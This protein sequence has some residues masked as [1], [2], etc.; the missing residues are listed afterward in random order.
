MPAG[1]RATVVVDT[2]GADVFLT[3]KSLGWRGTIQ[4]VSRSGLLPLAHFKG[5]EYNEF[6]SANVAQSRLAELVESI[7]RHCAQL[8]ERGAN[9][10]IL[11]DKLRP[12]SQRIWQNFTLDEK[13]EFCRRYRSRWNTTR[14]RIA[15]QIHRQLREAIDEGTLKIV[16]GSIDGLEA[17]GD[18]VRVRV[19]GSDGQPQ[20]L[21]AGLVVNCT[22]PLEKFTQA[23]TELFCNLLE[24]GLIAPDELDMGV[25][26]GPDFAVIDRGGSPSNFLY[27]MGPLLKGSLWET[28]AVP[29]LRVQAFRVASMLLEEVPSRERGKVE[30]PSQVDTEVLEY[31]I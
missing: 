21:D 2:A 3:L 17:A 22:G 27:A 13:R 25:Q 5:I 18:R 19:Q 11:V 4:A 14:H 29:E 10:A 15:P 20:V 1:R 23:Q 28:T 16:R 30:W 8:T 12:Y 9:P 6:P 26:V 7:E 31:Y 24:R